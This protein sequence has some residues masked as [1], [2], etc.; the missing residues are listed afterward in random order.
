MLDVSVCV[1]VCGEGGITPTKAKKRGSVKAIEIGKTGRNGN[2]NEK[3]M[4]G[5]LMNKTLNDK[6]ITSPMMMNK[7]TPMQV[8][9]NYWWKSF[10]TTLFNQPIR[11]KTSNERG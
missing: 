7:I 2:S 5:I 9:Y 6:L 8:Y 1:C 10:N 11:L 4:S 3:I